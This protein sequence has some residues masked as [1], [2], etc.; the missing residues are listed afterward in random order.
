VITDFQT[1]CGKDG[2]TAAA[3]C[4]SGQDREIYFSCILTIIAGS[5]IYGFVFGLWHSP[6]QAC[7]SM[8]KMP[9]LIILVILASSTI[10]IMLAMVMDMKLRVNEIF[11][12]ISMSLAITSLILLAMAPVML[13][14][15]LQYPHSGDGTDMVIY[16][17]LL[18]AHTAVIGAAGI[19]GNIRLFRMLRELTGDRALA[20]KVICTWIAVSG[21]AGCQLSWLISPFLAR[22]DISVLFFNDNAF[23]SN[24]FEY[25]WRAA[26][27]GFGG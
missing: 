20:K 27:T 6:E 16:R 9:L 11:K 2:A 10:N 21:F 7:Y 18:F 3:K 19:T 22:P 8:L 25:L 4:R 17:A 1:F 12:C 13:F 15:I 5:M 14:F 24:F 26:T 23:K